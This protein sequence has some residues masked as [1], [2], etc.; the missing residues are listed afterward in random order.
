MEVTNRWLIYTC[1]QS[2]PVEFDSPFVEIRD[3]GI[4]DANEVIIRANNAAKREGTRCWTREGIRLLHEATG[5][6]LAMHE[7]R[8]DES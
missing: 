7:E 1:A 5:Q 2:G 8:E 6:Y 4:P 3:E